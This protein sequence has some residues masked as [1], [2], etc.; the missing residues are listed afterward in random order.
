MCIRDSLGVLWSIWL[1]LNKNLW[2]SSFVLLTSGISLLLLALFYWVIDVRGWRRW[3]FFFVVIGMNAIT[4]YLLR[5]FVDFKGIGE[6][7]F[8]ATEARVHPAFFSAVELATGWL[9]LYILYRR[10]LFFRV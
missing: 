2:T 3:A 5:K 6:V 9:F 7:I 8:A 1:P 4:I 10:K